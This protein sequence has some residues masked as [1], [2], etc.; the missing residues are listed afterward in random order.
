MF[1]VTILCVNYLVIAQIKIFLKS[2]W[3]SANINL[4]LKAEKS[5][6]AMELLRRRLFYF[7]AEKSAIYSRTITGGQCTY[8]TKYRLT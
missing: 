7:K 4:L 6:T 2:K 8:C 1:T 5:V 3:C